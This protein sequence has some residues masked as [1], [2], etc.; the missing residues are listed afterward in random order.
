MYRD[1]EVEKINFNL[2]RIIGDAA[3]VYQ[4]KYQ[5]PDNREY[6]NVMNDILEYIKENELVI[7]GGY[8]Q[9]KLIGEK[10]KSDE[11]YDELSRADIEVYSSNPIQD[12]MRIGEMLFKK[13]YKYISVT[14]G[15]HKETYKVFCNFINY[16]DVSYIDENILKNCPVI[17]IDGVRYIH[18]HFMVT[19]AFRVYTD[20]MTSYFRLDKTFSRFTVLMKHYPF[21][22]NKKYNVK[23][24]PIPEN[25]ASYIKKNIIHNSDYIVVG[26]HAFNYIAKKAID[27]M[28]SS[29]M[30]RLK[31]IK[32]GGYF[33]II[34]KN[35][36]EDSKKIIS[37]LKDKKNIFSKKISYKRYHPFFQFYDEMIEVY[38]DNKLIMKIYGNNDRCVVYK[39]SEKKY[40]KFATFQLLILYLLADYIQS[41]VNKDKVGEENAMS[42]I[43][44]IYRLRNSFL[45]ELGF[46]PLDETPFKEF[47]IDCIGTPEDPLR[48]SFLEGAKKREQGKKMKFT[49]QPS[50]KESKAPNYIFKNQ[51]G[52]EIQQS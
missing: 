19:D 44:E 45:D 48:K 51:S 3:K 21:D 1:E 4:E 35:L 12:S 11:F 39:Y 26:Q 40:T 13:N 38:S 32:P 24:N 43:T 36:K 22:L 14:E 49:Y 25:I 30:N 9:N 34:V 50:D 10:N 2:K 28:D 52:K 42:M 33:Q 15:V 5:E 29:K 47:T 17:V 31:S 46:S 18:P 8:A 16:A 41:F 27:S 7:Y 37:I 23:I 6:N 20:P